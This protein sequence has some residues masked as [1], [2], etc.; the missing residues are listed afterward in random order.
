M[1]MP[2]KVITL[3]LVCALVVAWAG[4]K[5][6]AKVDTT[7]TAKVTATRGDHGGLRSILEALFGGEGEDSKEGGYDYFLDKNGNGVDDRL[8]SRKR[9][10]GRLSKSRSRCTKSHRHRSSKRGR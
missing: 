1:E 2:K 9:A 5:P 10:K 4:E 8:E 7:D 3:F 6:A